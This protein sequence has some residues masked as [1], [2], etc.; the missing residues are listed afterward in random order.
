METVLSGL[1]AKFIYVSVIINT[2][3]RCTTAYLFLGTTYQKRT[4]LFFYI[5]YPAVHLLIE[6]VLHSTLHIQHTLHSIQVAHSPMYVTYVA[7]I[8]GVTLL[9][10]QLYSALRQLPL[11]ASS[12]FHRFHSGS[13]EEP[14]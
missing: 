10:L 4:V 6:Q 9:L 14:S 11:S 13:L 3:T 5:L 8:R 1:R 2:T 12:G 7:R